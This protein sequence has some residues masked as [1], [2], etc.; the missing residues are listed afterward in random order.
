[1]DS[2]QNY[3]DGKLVDP[4]GGQYSPV[5]DP[6]TAQPYVMA[7][8]SREADIDMAC[9]AALNAFDTWRMTT[10]AER[11]IALFRAADALQERKDDL[12]DAE[13]RNTGKP[14]RVMS[15]DEFPPIVDHLRFYAAAC[16]DMRGLAG[17][18]FLSGYDSTVRREPIG[19]CG[20]VA[21][22]NYP[23]NMG[24]W[25]FG[26]AIAAGNTVVLKPSDTTPCSTVLAAAILGEI[27]PPGV[28]NV[29]VGDRD[30]GRALVAHPIPRL[31]SVTGSERAGVEVS[32]S[33]AADLKRVHLELGGKAP[34]LVF[35]DV[36]L[37]TVA[38][39]IA[40]AAFFNAGQDC[41]AACRV[42]VA[43]T[44]H[45]RFVAELVRAAGATRHGP[46]DDP[47][48]DYGPLNSRAHLDK[49]TGFFDRL[50][51]HAD[52]RTGGRPDESGVG[53]YF[54]PTV[55]TGVRQDDELVQEEVF[56][57]VVTVQSFRDEAEAVALANDVR[58]GLAAGIWTH[59]HDRVVRVSAALD[60]GKVWVNCHLVIAAEMPNNG[61][62]HSGNGND[63]SAYALEEYTRLKHVMTHVRSA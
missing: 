5:I 54:P 48:A 39:E 7:P 55:V 20:Q 3:I 10:P 17:G 36:D 15:E 50:P 29:V 44:V 9:R 6:S 14:R 12:V 49:V 51:P 41:E 37:A 45:D 60:F 22:W 43:E 47:T 16:R 46:P 34:V 21:P 63:V 4:V 26:P 35:D 19:V 62:K 53:Y 23:L 28:L 56:G 33:A 59:D 38:R 57:P 40:A 25:K 11:S 58:F 31:I 13:C 42:L 30:T 32:A 24:L 61:Y 52:V 8:L 18:S 1:M 2:L 27:L